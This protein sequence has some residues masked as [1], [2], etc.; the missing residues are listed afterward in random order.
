M[1]EGKKSFVL[2]ADLIHT[3][4]KLPDLDAGKLFKHLLRYVN[5]Q[6]PLTDEILISAVFEPIK[7]Q[8]KRDLDRWGEQIEQRRLAGIRSAEARKAKFNE[9]QRKSTTVESRQRNS[10][11]NVN[12]NVNVINI[13]SKKIPFNKSDLFDRAIFRTVFTD[14]NDNK[15]KHYYQAAINWSEQGNRY[16]NWASA[17]RTWATKDETQGKVT[18]PDPVKENKNRGLI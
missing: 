6:D 7:Q 8:L 14:W 11:D 17:I 1:A 16:V 9:S 13:K 5:D 18:F 2:Y 15:L 10:T 12:D 3:V 4:E